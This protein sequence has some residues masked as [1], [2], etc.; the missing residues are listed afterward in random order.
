MAFK[1]VMKTRKRM[2]GQKNLS[3]LISMVNLALTY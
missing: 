1:Q 3:T 2:L